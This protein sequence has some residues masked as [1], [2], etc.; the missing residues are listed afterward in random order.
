[1]TTRY[2][3]ADP[4]LADLVASEGTH[5]LELLGHVLAPAEAP[6]AALR[7]R[8]LAAATHEGRLW[9]F[10]SEVAE[11]L[12][13]SLER[14][15]ALLDRLDDPSVWTVV[16]PGIALFWVEGGPR[17]QSAT[18]GFVRIAAGVRT[19]DHEHVGRETMFVLQG[20]LHDLG[21]GLVGRPGDLLQ[22]EGGSSHAIEA[23]PHGVDVL[24]LAIAEGGIRIGGTLFGPR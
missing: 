6:C 24:Q 23:L 11:L 16:S 8:L 18:R 7:E 9:R 4:F 17:V 21:N 2:D 14:A 13:V 22:N 1:V 3:E 5:A 12:D 10:A 19:P 20:A 15:R